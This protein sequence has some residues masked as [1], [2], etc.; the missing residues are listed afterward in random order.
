MGRSVAIEL[1]K[2]GANIV[3]VSRTVS[4]LEAALNDIKVR[5]HID[6]QHI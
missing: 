5:M 1:S 2:K 6:E 4:K 3:I